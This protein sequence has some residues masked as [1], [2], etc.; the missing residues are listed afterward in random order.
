MVNAQNVVQRTISTANPALVGP[1]TPAGCTAIAC[2]PE[3][4]VDWL[5]TPGTKTFKAPAVA[6]R[7]AAQVL[8]DMLDTI[9]DER[10][11][12]MMTVLT[13]GGAKKTEYAA[14]QREWQD[15]N[16]MSLNSIIAMALTQQQTRWPWAM[17]EV[18]DTDDTLQVVMA[19][20]KAGMDGSA[21]AQRVAA[22]AQKLKRQLKAATPAQRPA[23]FAARSWPT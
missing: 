1:N 5:Y 21:L 3:V 17:A 11:I 18:A 6:V 8:A 16:S 10:E 20:I 22:R 2:S 9:D 23:I 14:K 7:T 19:R 4:M 12:R 15:Y 13:S